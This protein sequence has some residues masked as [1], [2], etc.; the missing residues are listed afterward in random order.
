MQVLI[1]QESSEIVPSMDYGI[2]YHLYTTSM[3]PQHGYG[4]NSLC[5]CTFFLSRLDFTVSGPCSGYVIELHPLNI[6]LIRKTRTEER[7]SV[8]GLIQISFV[9]EQYKVP[10]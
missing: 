5:L 8:K 3:L 4:S 1:C 6:L 2:F 9:A 10:K 7:G